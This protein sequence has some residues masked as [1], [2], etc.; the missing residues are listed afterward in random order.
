MF[1]NKNVTLGYVISI[2]LHVVITENYNY[3]KINIFDLF[4]F[5]ASSVQQIQ[6]QQ[7]QTIN[8]TIKTL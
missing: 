1:C 3:V 7:N 6:L 5:E 8:I 2:Q 4:L